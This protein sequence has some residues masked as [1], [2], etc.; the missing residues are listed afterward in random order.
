MSAA[1]DH[2][3][4]DA[5]RQFSSGELLGVSRFGSGNIN[6]TYLARFSNRSLVVQRINGKVFPDPRKIAGNMEVVG[7]CIDAAV[8]PGEEFVYPRL[9]LDRA[10]NTLWVDPEGACWRASDFVGS[11]ATSAVVKDPTH[12]GEVGRIIGRFH[13]LTAGVD[14]S[15]LHDTLPGYRNC[16]GHLA[17]Y[18]AA[19]AAGTGM[20]RTRMGAEGVRDMMQFV[21]ARRGKGDVLEAAGASGRCRTLVMHGDP[22]ADNVLIDSRS[23]RGVGLVDFDTVKPGLWAYDFGDACRSVCNPAGEDAPAGG[24]VF[25]MARFRAFA[26]AYISEVLPAMPESERLVLGPSVWLQTFELGVRFLADYLAGDV[27]FRVSDGDRNRRRAMTQFDLCRDIEFRAAEI[28][29]AIDAAVTELAGGT[30]RAARR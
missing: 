20:G 9:V 27:Y 28:D 1:P 26:G 15:A 12:A 22:K 23:G 25:D 19:V 13:R 17:R 14:V 3:A 16:P 7:R 29:E 4:H 5:A 30:G 8:A 2:I 11:A 6:D 18:D 21:A 24:A 10:G